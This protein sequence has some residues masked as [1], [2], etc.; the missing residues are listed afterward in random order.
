M[1]SISG[2]IQLLFASRDPQ[3]AADYA[4][5]FNG[6][7]SFGSY[8][9]AADDSRV[10]A[11]YLCTPHHL[12]YQH[13]VLAAAAGKHILVEKPIART[14]TEAAAVIEA[15]DR[16]GVIL[17]VAENYRFL[18]GVRLAKELIDTGVIGELRLIQLQEEGSFK[19][20]LWRNNRD[21]TGGGVFIDGGIHKIDLLRYLAGTPETIYAAQV[22]PGQTGLDAED[23]LVMI[24]RSATGVVGIINHS[25]TR[26][27]RV[28]PMWLSVSGTKG[29]IYFELGV[30]EL[31]LDDGR[32]ERRLSL[33]QD[34]YGLVPMMLEFRDC[35]REGREP[36]MSGSE[37]LADVALVVKAYESM[38]TGRTV[39]VD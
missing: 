26:T 23:G 10:D 22:P 30:A 12:H 1:Q 5:E 35:I 36:Q 20:D 37:G 6:I 19:P 8:Q 2:D 15:A 24:T 29:R 3:R 9:E 18:S 14:P 16:A 11:M 38:E 25:W 17:M 7:G 33:A 39:R 31:L 4:A 28:Q 27:A 21:L 13:V 34:H 32:S